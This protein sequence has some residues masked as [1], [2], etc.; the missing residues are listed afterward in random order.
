MK[1]RTVI[2]LAAVVYGGVVIATCPLKSAAGMVTALREALPGDLDTLV[3]DLN[4]SLED[5]S[6]AYR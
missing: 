4:D 6:D 3:Q 2:V 1:R 5:M